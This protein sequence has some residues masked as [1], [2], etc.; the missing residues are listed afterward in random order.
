MYIARVL[1]KMCFICF[2]LPLKLVQVKKQ[3]FKKKHKHK[4]HLG[5]GKAHLYLL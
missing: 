3:K 5:H 1:G 4:K 2:Q